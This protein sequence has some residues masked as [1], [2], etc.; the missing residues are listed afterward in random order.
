MIIYPLPPKNPQGNWLFESTLIVEDRSRGGVGS[1]MK[2]KPGGYNIIDLCWY[3]SKPCTP[4]E[5]KDR[6][7]IMDVHPPKEH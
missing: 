5:Q 6:W 2:R 3:G 4:G 7:K 1:S